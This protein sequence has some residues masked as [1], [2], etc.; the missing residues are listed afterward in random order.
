[1]LHEWVRAV[2]SN[3]L[4]RANCASPA[5][6]TVRC[7]GPP[8]GGDR[9]EA[10]ANHL[11]L[12]HAALLFTRTRNTNMPHAGRVRAPTAVVGCL[13]EMR[14]NKLLYVPI[15]NSDI[16]TLWISGLSARVR[17]AMRGVR[18]VR[19]GRSSSGTRQHLPP[20]V[21]HL[22]EMQ[23]RLATFRSYVLMC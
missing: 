2:V 19:R 18:T 13:R 11:N 5:E 1:M 17:H 7:R 10:K 3:K 8:L 14:L 12:N 21:L 23:V 6:V 22:R 16:V 20:E 9:L 4:S 15:L